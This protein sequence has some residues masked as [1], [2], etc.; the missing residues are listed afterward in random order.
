MTNIIIE[1]R[2]SEIV[3]WV[4]FKRLCQ[5]LSKIYGFNF[6]IDPAWCI[7][8]RNKSTKVKKIKEGKKVSVVNNSPN[9]DLKIAEALEIFNK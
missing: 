7:L 9:L 5:S 3:E 8:V 6:K 4:D 2:F 1:M